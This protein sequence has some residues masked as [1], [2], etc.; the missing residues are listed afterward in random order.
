[1]SFVLRSVRPSDLNSLMNLTRQFVL[2]NLPNNRETLTE[3][4]ERSVKSFAGALKK[5]EAEYLFVAEDVETGEVVGSSLIMAKHGTP[6]SPHH[7]F[8]IEHRNHY[9]KSLGIGF[10]QP[11]LRLHSETNGPS[12][13]GGLLVHEDYRRRP[14]KL[15]YQISLVRFAY[16]GIDTSRFEKRLICELSPPLTPDGRSEFWEALGRRFT[17]L[18]YQEAD[19]LSQVDSEFIRSLFPTGDIYLNLLDAKARVDLGQVAEA[20]RPAVHLL[21]KLGFE[22]LEEVDPFD[23]GPHYG[24]MVADMEIIKNCRKVKVAKP[25]NDEFEI[26]GF[27]SSLTQDGDF[28][29]VYGPIL[30]SE[31]EVAFPERNRSLLGVGP[32]DQ[33]YV[34]FI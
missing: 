34:T 18:P 33:V 10:N 9:S 20:T 30:L 32:G 27:V 7:A 23:G 4:I 26:R 8:K 1:M 28:R 29:S 13:I 19:R 5:E 25:K 22:Y 15:G 11:V 3:K 16:M 14:E 24:V 6:D 21:K 2:L 12:E 31:S 17:G